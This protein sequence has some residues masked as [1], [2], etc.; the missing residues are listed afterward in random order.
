MISV[1]SFKE[2]GNDQVSEN[3][4]VREFASHDGADQVI[5]DDALVTILQKIRNYFKLSVNINSGYRTPAHNKA[6]G[7]DP[8]SAH[9]AG[10][11]AD[12]TVGRKG[13]AEDVRLVAMFAE[14]AGCVRIGVYHLP[15]DNSFVHI[16]SGSVRQFWVEPEP[17]YRRYP[18][19][20]LPV[21]QRQFIVFT[22]RFEVMTAQ[23]I[24]SRTGFYTGPVDGRYGPG[25]GF[26]KAV[27]AF[28][29]AKR[30]KQSGKIDMDT[31]KQLFGV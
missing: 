26:Y 8:N 1:Y 14:A 19:T 25:K 31:W 16:G 18:K 12:I 4:R 5:I 28:Q 24:L 23:T 15:N 6:I 29:K 20:M 13:L 11:A 27:L 10:K 22:N 7:G 3:F 21:L 2:D 17:G 9:M 30:L